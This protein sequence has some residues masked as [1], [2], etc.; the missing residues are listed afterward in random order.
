MRKFTVI[1]GLL[2]AATALPA[3]AMT[4]GQADCPVALAPAG[5]AAATADSLLNYSDDKGLDPKVE[6]A[7]DKLVKA[8]IARERVTADK[9]EAYTNYVMSALVVSEMKGRLA[10]RSVSVTVID[11][12]FDIGPG[13]SNPQSKDLDKA[14]FAEIVDKMRAGGVDINTLSDAALNDI[15]TYVATASSMYRLA[16]TL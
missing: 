7:L 14:A 8:C 13:R 11:N 4:P 10:A 1:A 16:A 3:A 2:L 15:S 9:Q 5:L 6:A 12:A